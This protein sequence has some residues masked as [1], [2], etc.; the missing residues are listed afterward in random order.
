MTRRPAARSAA[1]CFALLGLSAL[2]PP[3]SEAQTAVS[4][5]TTGDATFNVFVNAVPV[6]FERVQL[7]RTDD[8][9]VI[10]AGGQVTAPVTSDTS[11]FEATYDADWRPLR[12]QVQGT[13]DGVPFALDTTIVDGIAT[14]ELRQQETTSDIL[15][16]AIDPGAV[17]LPNL[18][19]AAYEALAVRLAASAQ[20]DELPIFVAPGGTA[21]VRV[22]SVGSQRIR[23]VDR[24]IVATTYNL[25]ILDP[26]QDFPAVVWV[27]E[28]R[29][30]L[31]VTVP[32]ASIDVARQDLALA[33]TR[34][35]D[36]A[37]PGDEDVRVQAAGFSLAATITT[38]LDTAPAPG[39]NGRM[40]VV[41]V[42]GPDAS[43]RNEIHHG[44]SI[45]GQLAGAL[46]DRGVVAARYD[47]RGAG[48]SGG[49]PESVT[50]RDYA[51]DVRE[52]VRFLERRDDVNRDRIAVVG[53]DESAWIGMM[54][55]RRENRIKGL[56]VLAAPSVTGAQRVME[57]QLA[58]LDQMGATE[59]QR[60]ERID[61]Q[62][63]INQAVLEE[64]PWEGIPDALRTQADTPWFRSFLAFDPADA[65][66]RVRQPMLVIQ[67][68]LDQEVPP[69]HA[70]RLEAIAGERARRESTLEVA[71]LDGLN[72]L[73]TPAETGS[74]DEY[75]SLAET[76]IAPV[77][78][79]RIVA[80][81]ERLPGRR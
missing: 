64:G 21:A 71:R 31:R 30:L 47:R 32:M 50:L 81:I 2:L 76:Q 34:L 20:G 66:S 49:R 22:D 40:A 57:Q 77:V 61:L 36:E 5:P 11:L 39:P 10:R 60:Q 51:E 26:Q 18:L 17:M 13:R 65:L 45:F 75:A 44:V 4:D 46:A 14:S 63:R 16:I 41:L 70:D 48:Q 68:A 25:T 1:A 15:E 9:W 79:D 38:P 12:L 35:T 6:G 74:V 53:Y 80:W 42:P 69:H 54:A 24:P 67:G 33:S 55:A 78:A 72:H 27:D 8:G 58:A 19:F 52:V 59:A 56:I 29:R 7:L 23:T 3:A 62:T 28:H 37:H 73:L 43:D